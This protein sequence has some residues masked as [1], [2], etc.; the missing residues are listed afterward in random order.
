MSKLIATRAI[1]GAH[2]LVARAEAELT[3]AIQEKGPQ[4]KVEF[5]NTGYYL[6]ISHGILGLKIQTLGG[7][8]ELLEEAKKLL[9]P[10][11]DEKLWLPYLGRTLDAGMAALFADEIIEAIKYTQDLLPYLPEPHPRD[12][13][14]WLGAASDVILRERGIE[15]VD[16]T[17][18]GFAACVGYCPTNEIAVRIARELQEKNLYVFMSAATNG[19]SMA[20]QLEEE[21]VQMGWET[22]LVPFGDDVTATIHSLGFA[23][24]VALSF[25]GAQPGDF[26]RVLRYNK[27]RVFAFVLAL[28]PVDDEK[29][30][31]AAGA[32]NY[33]FPTISETDIDQILPTG[34]CTYEHVVSPVSHDKI[35][36]KAIEVRGLKITITKVPIPVPFGPAFQ[37]ERVRKEDMFVELAGQETPG[38]EFVTSK[39]LQEVEDGKIEVIGPEIDEVQEGSQLPVAIWVE[40]AGREMQPDFEPILERQIHEFINCANGVFHMGQRDVNWIRI[41]KEAKNKGFKFRHFG[42]ILHA[43]FHGDYGKI[44]DKVQIKIY[45][46]ERD[47]LD[48]IER[49][50]QT[51]R[52]REARIA[53][54]TDEAVDTFYSCTLCQSFAPNHV[55]MITPER[56]GLCGAYNWLDGKAAHRINPTGPNQPVKKGKVIDSLK[57]QWQEINEFVFQAS[58]KTLEMFNAYSIIENPMTSCG[59]FECISGVLPSA[60]GIMI[61]YREYTGMT[62]TG[63]KF[64]TLAGTVGGGMQTPGF[65]GHSK[66]YIGSQ[67]FIRGEGGAKRIVWMNRALKEELEPVLRRIGEQEGMNHFIEM[68][69]D[70]TVAITEEEVLSHITQKNHPALSMPPLL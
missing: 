60:N 6:P 68:I 70:E 23:T 28:G 18:P 7:L 17:A 63:M 16:G 40:V 8:T 48:L 37:G 15:F 47:V 21:G 51:Y 1:R 19:R 9:P 11:P 69:A 46:R 43:K 13:Q 32:I 26:E 42:S 49:A 45:T 4:T 24:R 53:D 61:V 20:R 2:T 25:G 33:G 36:A 52:K 67:K 29:H 66:Q 59:C 44:M 10:V 5:P 30:A 50:R 65:I 22:R 58:H 38:F 34:I 41:S 64:S 3:R 55:C 56:S 62:P 14:L 54:M 39:G 57:G 27:N 31:Q 35:V 12:G